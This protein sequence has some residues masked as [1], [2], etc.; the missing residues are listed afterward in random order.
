MALVLPD[1]KHIFYLEWKFPSKGGRDN[2]VWI[3][4]LDG[5]K[6]RQSLMLPAHLL[7]SSAHEIYNRVFRKVPERLAEKS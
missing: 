1:G 5:E 6:A 3:G 4:S 2:G 7:S